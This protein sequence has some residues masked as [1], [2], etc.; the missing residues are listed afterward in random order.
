VKEK[1]WGQNEKLKIST[2]LIHSKFSATLIHSKLQPALWNSYFAYQ[3]RHMS[4]KE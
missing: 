4:K 3:G 2:T 1:K